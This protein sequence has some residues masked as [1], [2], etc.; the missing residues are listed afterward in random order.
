[1]FCS[2]NDWNCWTSYI[3]SDLHLH[4]SGITLDMW[5]C[6]IFGSYIF[7]HH[8]FGPV[9]Q[10]AVG[11]IRTL[12]GLPPTA[13]HDTE[14]H[15]SSVSASETAFSKWVLWETF[16]SLGLSLF[17]KVEANKRDQVINWTHSPKLVASDLETDEA[18]MSR[19]AIGHLGLDSED[20]MNGEADLQ[21][22]EATYGFDM[23]LG[24]RPFMP[25]KKICNPKL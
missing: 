18:S 12:L 20:E 1:M 23:Q 13:A 2:I 8:E 11:Q 7:Y 15:I 22:E 10:V 5:G 21:D 9:M 17:L 24:G 16:L 19:V 25:N 6:R 3:A 14:M 4:V